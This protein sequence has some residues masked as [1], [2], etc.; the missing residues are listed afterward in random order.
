MKKKGKKII[1]KAKTVTNKVNPFEVHI[2][3]KKHAI[4][5]QKS[6]DDHGLPGVSRGKAYKKVSF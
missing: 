4:L 2:N 6:K 5:G 1:S 3:H